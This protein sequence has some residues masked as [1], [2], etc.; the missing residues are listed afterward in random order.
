MTTL[1]FRLTIDGIDDETLVVRDYQGMES[2]SDS[3]DQQGHPVHGYRYTIDIASRNSD[4]TFEQMVDT[5][6]LLEVLRDNEVVQRVHG[7]IRS[8][9][10][11]DTGH[12]HTFYS[13]TLVP[14][15]ERLSLRHNSRIF[16]QLDV[17]EI[18]SILFQEMNIGDFAFS[19]KRECTKREYCVQYRETDLEF[20]HRLAAE[21][22]LMY[23]FEHHQDKHILV[24]TDSPEGFGRLATPVP[25]NAL[26]GGVFETPYVSTLTENKRT[27]VSDACLSDRSFKKPSYKI[28]HAATAQNMSYQRGDYEHFDHPGRFKDD[29]SGKAFTQVRLEALRRKA[30]TFEGKSNEARLQAGYRFDLMEHPDR[31]MNRN[32][33]LVQ[34]AY[35]GSQPQALEESGGS[36]ATTYANQFA[37]VPGEQ[38][39]RMA[40]HTKP[41]LKFPTLAKVVGPEG[42]EIY[43]DEY[44]RVKVQFPWDRYG[45][46]D[47]Q[48]SCWLRVSQGLAGAQYGMMAIPRI[49]H[50]VVVHFLN[51]DPD[52]PLITGRTYNANNV[53]PYPLPDNKTKTVLRTETHQGEGYNELSFEDQSGSEKIYLHAQKDTDMLIENDSTTYIKHNQSSTIDNDR[54]S[55][56]KANDHHTVSGEARTKIAQS[57]T[58]MIEGELHV[59]AGRVWVNESGTEIHI[60]AGEHVVIE[61]G[62]EITL[63]AGG[64]FVKVDPSGVSLV[65][66]GVNLNSGGSAGNGS[67]FG[68][69]AAILPQISAKATAIEAS[70]YSPKQ[71]TLTAL[72]AEVK[73][74]L[75]DMEKE[76]RPTKIAG[77]S[78]DIQETGS[79]T[80]IKVDPE[81]MYWPNY[82][83]INHREIAVEY[84]RKAVD[85]AVLSLED[86]EE[87]ANNLWLEYNGKETLDNTKKVWDGAANAHDAYRLAKGLGGMGV[88]VYTKEA[89]GR[90][91]VI[92]KGYKQHLKTLMKGNRWR[93]NN[94]QVV[95]LGLGT[96]NMARN[97]L[98]V[99]L[100]V[101]IIFAIAINAVDV[102]VHD[103]KTM[104]D[105]VGR[106]GTDIAKGIISTG[107]GTVAAVVASSFSLPLIVVGCT[108]AGVGFIVSVGLDWADNAWG[109][110]DTLVEKLK[111]VNE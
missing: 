56:I 57:Q 10:R 15:L 4:L 86:A 49:G 93:A 104:A 103:E 89:N 108:F 72:D 24:I 2:I 52:Q 109:V 73:N 90:D 107:A 55:H 48:S 45:N 14:S 30:H 70:A 85:L 81:N 21:E 46:S 61:A 58:L 80:P 102:F 53:A 88:V 12:H 100:V 62:N 36:G 7:V 34:I 28:S 87:F 18:F 51:G 63:K 54:Y 95:Q 41:I 39:W 96:Q 106:S 83:F 6:A 111:E 16:Q 65:G 64:S 20:F 5:T 71:A 11:G 98:R 75:P 23:R 3:V 99:G 43:C 25:Y 35:Q 105:L 69:E 44:G 60:K 47:D 59:K 9:S 82:D 1:K 22:G 38:V 66:P 17:P 76:S 101:D 74:Q 77:S 8:F 32:Y 97:M 68:G 29:A 42:E 50:E 84:T 19:V 37:A 92:I 94:P 26:S 31:E 27:E 33:L 40:P 91:Y 110:S 67:G 78:A 13:L 79:D